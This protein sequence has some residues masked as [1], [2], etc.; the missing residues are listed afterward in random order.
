MRRRPPSASDSYA[1][2]VVGNE[3]KLENDTLGPSVVRAVLFSDLS[4]ST[5]ALET[6]GDQAAEQERRAHLARATGLVERY[7][8]SVVKTL[9]DGL[10]AAFRS[11][12]QAVRCSMDMQRE[13]QEQ[14]GASRLRIGIEVGE[15]YEDET[16]DLHGMPVIVA[17][18]LCDVAGPGEILIS[19]L[20]A[21]LVTRRHSERMTRVGHLQLKG[22]STSTVAWR[23]HWGELVEVNELPPP[24]SSQ[25]AAELPRRLAELSGRPLVGRDDELSTLL[26]RWDATCD[27]GARVCVITGE[28]GA[29][30]SRLAAAVAAHVA[31]TGGRL[32]YGECDGDVQLFMQPWCEALTRDSERRT[33]RELR[34]LCGGGGE[35]ARL[36][37]AVRVRVSGLP[38]PVLDDPEGQR[39]RLYDAVLRYLVSASKIS[40]L[41][42]ILEDLHWADRGTVDLV[43]FLHRRLESS[44]VMILA[45]V[46]G[47]EV[48]ERVRALLADLARRDPLPPIAL[49]GLPAQ[50]VAELARATLGES[51]VSD[52]VV[53]RLQE[54]TN[55]N[56][57]FVGEVLRSLQGDGVIGSLAIP[58][59]V[60]ATLER[61]LETLAPEA[62]AHLSVAAVAGST[63]E[64]ALVADAAAVD[65]ETLLQQLESAAARRLIVEDAGV[66]GKFSFA[67]EIIRQVLLHRIGPTRL[68][69]IHLAVGEA[70]ERIAVTHQV[71]PSALARH[72]VAA[73]EAG[74]SP[75]AVHAGSAGMLAMERLGYAQA[76]EFFAAAVTA[77]DRG[78]EDLND[79]GR[80]GWLLVLQGE[81]T[82][83]AG[84]VA[85]AARLF[86]GALLEAQRFRDGGL[87]AA[88]ARGI[89]GGY[90]PAAWRRAVPGL[91]R[92]APSQ[93]RTARYR[94]PD[95]RASRGSTRGGI[96]LRA[97]CRRATRAYGPCDPACARQWRATLAR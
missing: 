35:L 18:R 9:G 79:P 24:P 29:G 56:P 25:E 6:A 51:R 8:G 55:G 2:V 12:L 44:R 27:A 31:A 45:T 73:G 42:I 83:R 58:P 84:R 88:V 96:T 74:A 53:R 61:T 13:D 34:T 67:H 5:A 22:L 94:G 36:V 1:L 17:R 52:E 4:D 86:H 43:S 80:R 76:A 23:V 60:E 77:L 89:S 63:F 54:H 50:A 20:V 82:T 47:A 90:D 48:G 68:A 46:R 33:V 39:G 97:S 91:A 32:L 3:I 93:R 28:A 69:R 64:L 49:S 62:I 95:A 30:K 11:A 66:P 78:P 81:A 87:A 72:F 10:F 65:S 41:L 59:T 71:E 38:N 37:P 7:G 19:E 14:A 57:L 70:L 21:G 16:G 85:E 40:P 15:P 75:A 26:A 92:R